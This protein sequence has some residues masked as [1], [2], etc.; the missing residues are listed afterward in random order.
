MTDWIKG[1][2]YTAMRLKL[3]KKHTLEVNIR[4]HRSGKVSVYQGV[5][6]LIGSFTDLFKGT[7][8]LDDSS[9]DLLNKH[10]LKIKVLS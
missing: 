6:K 8:D 3:D 9:M 1:H 7:L 4:Q 10:L 5:S 2:S